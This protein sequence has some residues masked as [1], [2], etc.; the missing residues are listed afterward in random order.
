MTKFGHIIANSRPGNIDVYLDGQPVLD[1]E[2]KIVKT[3][4][5]ILNISEGVHNITFSKQGYDLTTIMANVQEGSYT[6]TRAI[7]NTKF[8]RYP[9]MLSNKSSQPSPGWPT[10][11][12]PQIPYGNLVANTI[13]D[14][15]N[16]YID[17]QPILDSIDRIVTTPTTILNITTGR[18]K[19]TFRKDGYFDEDVYVYIDNGLYSDAFVVL[20]PKMVAMST[21]ISG[22]GDLFIDSNPQGAYVYIDGNTLIDINGH[23]I[24]TPVRITAVREG[25][26]EVQISLDQ[27]YSKKVFINIIPNQINNVS[28]TL[29]PI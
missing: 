11:P 6:Y 17:G 9:M 2:G 3:P 21:P 13:P 4:I 10:L 19:I 15:A 14:G 29:Q 20:R 16:V 26:H 27:Y 12:I 8:I 5:I 23:T 18:H 24:L 28:V 1:S 22:L 7:L 25:L